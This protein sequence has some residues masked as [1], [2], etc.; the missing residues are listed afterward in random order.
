MAR[1]S[2][3]FIASAATVARPVPVKGTMVS[4]SQRKCSAQSCVRGLNN[5]TCAPESGS[6]ANC[7]ADLRSE[8]QTQAKARFSANV[9]RA[10]SASEPLAE[11]PDR[12]V[13]GLWR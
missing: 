9:H 4:D 11:G 5:G 3:R 2:G 8:Q 6:G 1:I 7:C 10:G 12:L 13:G